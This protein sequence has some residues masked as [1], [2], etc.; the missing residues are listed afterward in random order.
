MV[1]SIIP[2]P[3]L[4][5]PLA[6]ANKEYKKEVGKVHSSSIDLF[7]YYDI[8]DIGTNGITPYKELVQ[9]FYR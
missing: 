7:V 8:D 3:C 1:P 6:C 9:A 5:L 4:V 2:F